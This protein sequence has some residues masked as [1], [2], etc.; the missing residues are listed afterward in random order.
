MTGRP[1]TF[2]RVLPLPGEAAS[3]YFSRLVM[4]E[5]AH[6]PELYASEIGINAIFRS[7]EV[8]ERIFRLPISEQD[9]E[10]LRYWT[11]LEKHGRIH[12]AGQVFGR[13]QFRWTRR[14][15]CR[16]CVAETPYHRVWWHLQCFRACPVHEC[17][18]EPLSYDLKKTGRW[19]PRF[20]HVV[21]ER[22]VH[23]ELGDAADTFES[24]IVR[25]LLDVSCQDSPSELSDFIECAPF[26]GRLLGNNRNPSIPPPSNKDWE[27]GY[28]ALKGGLLP[29]EDQVRSWLRVNAPQSHA[30]LVRDLIGWAA[31]YL[32]DEE[33]L[34]DPEIDDLP[35]PMHVKIS[36]I[37][38]AECRRVLG[39]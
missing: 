19:W 34:F 23:V 38:R 26:V 5:C 25:R 22:A 39:R 16:R 6:L 14:L 2:W 17:A 33:E 35:N 20:E 30:Y 18:L 36:A 1:F 32:A 37:V 9:K 27:V 12:L 28:H 29:F 8:L 13:D 11:P 24:H 7:E 10:R 31:E 3:S 15:H 4:D 21:K